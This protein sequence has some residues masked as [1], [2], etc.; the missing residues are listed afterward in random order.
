MLK[1]YTAFIVDKLNKQEQKDT[2]KAFTKFQGH[3]LIDQPRP[4]AFTRQAAI[5]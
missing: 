1:I 4:R 5:A 3:V 2:I